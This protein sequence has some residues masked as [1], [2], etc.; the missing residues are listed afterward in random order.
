[1]KIMAQNLVIMFAKHPEPG[2][3]KTRLAAE[4]GDA[5]AV[6]VYRA[7]TELVIAAV[8]RGGINE[9]AVAIACWPPEKINEMRQWLGPDARIITQQGHDLGSRMH[10]AFTE[11]FAGGHKKISIIGADCPAVT[12]ELLAQALAMLDSAEVVIGPAA[13]GG[14]YLMGLRRSIHALFEGIAWSSELVCRQTLAICS[15][16]HLTYALLPVL[17]DI[18]RADDLEHYRAQGILL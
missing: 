1:L 3:V 7:C 17:R 11:G 6:R 2:R 12:R 10:H 9:Y 15:R 8:A 4:L 16:L 5:E 13:D 18:D 14:Y